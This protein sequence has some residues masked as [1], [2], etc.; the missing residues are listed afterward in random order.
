MKE[1]E[2]PRPENVDIDKLL[3]VVEQST[4]FMELIALV[5]LIIGLYKIGKHKQAI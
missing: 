5:I 4:Q 2:I 3:S 1:G